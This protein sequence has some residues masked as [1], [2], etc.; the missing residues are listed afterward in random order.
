MLIAVPKGII[1]SKQWN[2]NKSV[3]DW[4]SVLPCYWYF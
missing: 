4:W 2:W 1:Y 3:C